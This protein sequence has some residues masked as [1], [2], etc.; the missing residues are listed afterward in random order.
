MRTFYEEWSMLEEVPNSNLEPVG[1]KI[2][3]STLLIEKLSIRDFLSIGFTLH[4]T[5]LSKVKDISERVF[6]ITKTANEKLT[7][8]ELELSIASDD[9]HH[10]GVL[11]NNFNS[12]LPSD[13]QSF[14]AIQSFKDEYLLNFINV[15][16]LGIRDKVEIDERIIENEIIHNIKKFILAF[17]KD[18]AFIRN[19][20]HLNAFNEDQYIDLLFFNRELNCM[21]VFELKMGKF[22]PSYLGQLSA[23]LSTLNKFERK[24]HENP[25]IGIILCKDVNDAF[26]D[27]LIQDYKN[28]MGVSRYKD[29]TDQIKKQLPSVEELKKLLSNDSEDQEDVENGA[30]IL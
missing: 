22:K 30:T 18:F 28:P 7:R 19:Q 13:L 27:F 6:Y 16:E 3:K 24:P 5:I 2:E 17:G 1:A 29:M 14:K 21:V 12:T 23:Y 10:Q 15:E 26:V 9:Y 20:Y 25:P 8:R 11:P 4:R